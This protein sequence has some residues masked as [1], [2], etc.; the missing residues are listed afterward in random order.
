[1]TALRLICNLAEERRVVTMAESFSWDQVEPI[2][3][4]LTARVGDKI[5]DI[6]I[7]FSVPPGM[8]FRDVQSGAWFD[9]D[10]RKLAEAPADEVA[11]REIHLS[12]KE[13]ASA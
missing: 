1:M 4:T 12:Q 7:P 8:I 5:M 13:A 6:L 11:S 3:L 9:S 10:G 2:K